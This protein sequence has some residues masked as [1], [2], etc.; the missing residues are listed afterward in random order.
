MRRK[1]ALRVAALTVF[2]LCLAGFAAT[3]TADTIRTPTWFRNI[4]E[5]FGSA[6]TFNNGTTVNFE[7]D[8]AA[9]QIDATN[10]TQSAAELNAAGAGTTATLTPSIVSNANLV[11]YGRNGTFTNTLTIIEGALTDSTVVSADIKDGAVAN[12]DLAANSVSS[13]NLVAA[14]FGGIT[15][16][17]GGHV[18]VDSDASIFASLTLSS[19]PVSATQATITVTCK[20]INGVTL[21]AAKSYECWFTTYTQQFTPSTNGIETFT[22]VDHGAVAAYRYVA[23]SIIGGYLVTSHTDGT[24][25]FLVTCETGPSTNLFKAL[26]PNGALVSVNVAFTAP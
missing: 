23:A 10:M 26:S 6:V 1:T 25:D 19:S 21:E 24:T 8:T 17:A 16:G 4:V 18:T 20:D 12:G 22:F 5:F 14:D 3:A 7:N 11:V 2:A 15:V 9:Y 13:N